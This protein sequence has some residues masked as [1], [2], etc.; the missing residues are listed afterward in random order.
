[1]SQQADLNPEKMVLGVLAGA[2][3]YPRMMIEGARRAGVR[4]VGCGFRGAAGKDLPPLCDAWRV[5][6]VGAV[7][8]PAEYFKSEGVTHVVLTGQIKPACI[9]TMW[10]DATARRK[11]AELD[12][13]NAHTIFG[14]VCD[15]IESYGM[16]VL[17][18]T[19]FMEEVMPPAGHLAGPAPTPE[20]VDEA[21]Y[22]LSLAREIARLDIG[23]SLMVHGRRVMAVEAFKGTNECLHAGGNREF[24]VT[25]CKVTKPGHDMRFDVPCIGLGTIRHA[26][27]ANVNHIVFEANRTILFQREAVIRLCNE[28]GITLHA[29]EVPVP[30]QERPDPTHCADDAAH[31]QY[32]ADELAELGIGHCAVV[33]E[34]VV[35]AVGDPEGPQKCISR[36][37]AYMKRLRF[38]R[39]ANWLVRVL[40]GRRSTPPAP[41]V[42]GMAEGHE[43]TEAEHAA[44]HRAGIRTGLGDPEGNG[45]CS[46]C[47]LVIMLALV[48]LGML[49]WHSAPLYIFPGYYS[50]FPDAGYGAPDQ[51]VT[52]TTDDG[53]KLGGWFFNRGS[54][55]PLVAFYTGNNMNVGALLDFAEKDTSRSYLMLNYRGYGDSEGV[56]SEEILVQDAY[57]A[58]IW[59]SL[60]TGKPSS[61]ALVGYSIGS[62]VAVQLAATANVDSLVLICPYD[63]ITDV[64]CDFV[65]VLPRILPIDSFRS[66]DYAPA[67]TCPVT[68]LRAEHDTLITA[69]HTARLKEAFISTSPTEHV[70]SA[71]HNTIFSHPD[72]YPLIWKALP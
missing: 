68:I 33:C 41:M 70:L 57:Q 46:G 40:L 6:R 26:V 25:L 72:F 52:L 54:G 45:G 32:L 64:A 23:Q 50:E 44:A 69:P 56:P 48:A 17:P 35:I 20:Q 34:G 49:V 10:P 2:G 27:K 24:P 37:G 63:T 21:E 28:H 15:F 71:D 38:V 31:A 18:S 3:E 55:K 47:L 8:G 12:R 1:M 42:L 4:V 60:S 53:T 29:M 19:A 30:A 39:L 22:G 5:F 14:A 58:L 59:A 66:V 36:A 16:K 67:I 62:G 9:Y 61:V 7:E 51:H 65:P 43:L 13:R 11:L